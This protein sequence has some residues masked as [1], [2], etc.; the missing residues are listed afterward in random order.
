MPREQLLAVVAAERA[1]GLRAIRAQLA[2]LMQMI[3]VVRHRDEV[4]A[5]PE[6]P[7]ELAERSIDVGHVVEHPRGHGAVEG[8][9][10]E[11]QSLDVSELCVDAPIAGQL[12]HAW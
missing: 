5:G 6:H 3:E 8:R 7:R 4:T 1:L 2:Q 10:G 9:I 12:D 11:R